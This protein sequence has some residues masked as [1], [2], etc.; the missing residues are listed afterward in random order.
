MLELYVTSK[1][2]TRAG[3][4]EDAACFNQR[5]MFQPFRYLYFDMDLH[6]DCVLEMI[7]RY[8]YG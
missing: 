6:S 4:G 5:R 1:V 7:F 8:G 3:Q 2:V